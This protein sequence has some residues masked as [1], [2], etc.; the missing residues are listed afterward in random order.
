MHPA[1][2][3]FFFVSPFF[4]CSLPTERFV[5]TSEHG[6]CVIPA[7]AGIQCTRVDS[8][9]RGYDDPSFQGFSAHRGTV[10][11]QSSALMKT[12]VR[13][14]GSLRNVFQSGRIL[15]TKWYWQ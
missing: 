11:D 1:S 10:N 2:C 4:V 5:R 8:R 3:P 6:F 13:C 9:L 7:Q 14:L 15:C 12:A